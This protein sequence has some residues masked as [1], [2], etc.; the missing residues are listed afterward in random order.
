MIGEWTHRDDEAAGDHLVPALHTLAVVPGLAFDD[1]SVRRRDGHG[2]EVEGGWCRPRI[3]VAPSPGGSP[4]TMANLFTGEGGAVRTIQFS[5]PGWG[6]GVDH[7]RDS[8]DYGDC[9]DT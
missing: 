1:R 6:L 4:T 7:R 3:D 8:C 9:A 5:L 2:K